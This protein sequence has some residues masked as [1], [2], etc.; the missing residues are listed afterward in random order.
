MM[1]RA[2]MWLFCLIIPFLM[3]GGSGCISHPEPDLAGATESLVMIA[4]QDLAERLNVPLERVKLVKI[5]P[6]DWPDTSLGSP[7]PGKVYAQVI[8]S[9]YR[10][11]L[12]DGIKQYE[13]HSDTQN[14]VVYSG[15]D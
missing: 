8:T 4:R 14:R 10:I 9:G 1:K 7:E 5:E 11:I 2:D 13:Y 12:S 6:V 15:Q 3:F